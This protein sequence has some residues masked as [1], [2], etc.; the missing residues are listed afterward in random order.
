[1]LL[2]TLLMLAGLPLM[3]HAMPTAVAQSEPS[4][5]WDF[6]I[7]ASRGITLL[8]PNAILSGTS[9]RVSVTLELDAA[10][11]ASAFDG[12]L[13]LVWTTDDRAGSS[14]SQVTVLPTNGTHVQAAG[15]VLIT[16]ASRRIEV[17]L[18]AAHPTMTDAELDANA[19]NN[20]LLGEVGQA[21]PQL[22]DLPGRDCRAADTLASVFSL[23]MQIGTL[24]PNATAGEVWQFVISWW[25]PSVPEPPMQD[26]EV[27]YRWTEDGEPHQRTIPL[28]QPDGAYGS[29]PLF[30]PERE[31]HLA[32]DLD[33]EACLAG[34]CETTLGVNDFILLAPR[35]DAGT[36]LETFEASLVL[37]TCGVT[38]E[39]RFRA[40][41]EP[42]ELVELVI[43][44]SRLQADS[45]DIALLW[46]VVLVSAVG[47][48]AVLRRVDAERIVQEGLDEG[49]LRGG[50]DV[51]ARRSDEES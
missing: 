3:G 22:V 10:P 48:V 45:G 51:W 4:S 34:S 32:D 36:R 43:G 28:A 8:G 11:N 37:E 16:R 46:L 14:V 41:S 39:R 49:Y 38:A 42:P 15:E 18:R 35:D 26:V 12:A 6:S 25:P 29:D 50:A 19:S 31:V 47:L 23:E 17:S 44:G 5:A 2:L 30:H 33:A 7:N 40:T 24:G 13:S 9:V 1:M 27:R 20:V 21:L